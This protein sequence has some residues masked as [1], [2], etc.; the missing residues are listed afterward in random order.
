MS[1]GISRA[2]TYRLIGLQ[3]AHVACWPSSET[4]TCADAPYRAA[5]TR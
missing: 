5:V 1:Y 3:V 2:E 4:T